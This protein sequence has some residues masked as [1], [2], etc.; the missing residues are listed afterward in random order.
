MIDAYLL[1]RFAHFLGLLL[2]VSGLFAILKSLR[3][4]VR[5]QQR[6]AYAAQDVLPVLRPAYR[7]AAQLG[8][9]LAWIGGLA[10]VQL[11]PALRAQPWLHAKLVLLSILSIITVLEFRLAGRLSRGDDLR[12]PWWV[13]LVDPLLVVLVALAVFRPQ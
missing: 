1:G 7:F 9:I 12:I 8:M 10:M 2:W 13:R 3:I 11:N 5:L 4:F 6:G